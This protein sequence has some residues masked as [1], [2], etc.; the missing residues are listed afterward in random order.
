VK[1][2]IVVDTSGGGHELTQD[3]N[4]IRNVRTSDAEID[5]ATDEVTIASGILKRDTVCG[6]KMSVKLHR[7]VHKAVISK[8]DT[9]KK[10]INVFSLGEVV[11]IR[12]GCDL[13]PRK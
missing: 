3:V 9:V 10:I 6:T 4:D 12:C 5:K 7:S 1:E 8:T 2:M 13:N 11:A